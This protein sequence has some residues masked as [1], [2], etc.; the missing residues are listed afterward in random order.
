MRYKIIIYLLLSVVALTGCATFKGGKGYSYK[1]RKK[2]LKEHEIN[3]LPEYDIPVV[4]NDDVIAW[5]EYFQKK[6]RSSFARYL[7]R[8]GR[9][10][11]M[12]REIL[13]QYGV[14]GDMIYSALIESGF[15][16]HAYSR[17]HAVGPWQ[18]IKST[19][20]IYK[21]K[22]DDSVDERRDPVLSTHAAAQFLRDLYKDYGDWYL[23]LA[24]Y[25]AGPGKVNKA[26]KK[27]GSRDFWEICSH[28]RLFREET[29]NHIP[30]I[31]AAAIIAKQPQ[32][33]G[34]AGIE[35]DSPDEYDVVTVESQTDLE[36]V[37]KCA[38]VG[39]DDVFDL[40]PALFRGV[41]PSGEKN[42]Q[43]KVPKGKAKAFALAYAKLPKEDRI[44]YAYHRVKKGDTLSRIARKYGVSVSELKNWNGISNNRHLRISSVLKIY[45]GGSGPK[46]S[47]IKVAGVSK[48]RSNSQQGK[49]YHT[50]KSGETLSHVADRYVVKIKDV[51]RWNGI[52]NPKKVRAGKKLVIYGASGGTSEDG[53][54]VERKAVA[55]STSGNHNVKAG[56]SL[57]SIATAYGMSVDDLK[58]ANG[59]KKNRINPGMKLKV[60]ASAAAPTPKTVTTG[61]V[62]KSSS[63]QDVAVQAP[64][65]VTPQSVAQSSSPSNAGNSFHTVIE[66]ESLWRIANKYGLSIDEVKR[67]NGLKSNQIKPGM[68]LK[69]NKTTLES[70]RRSEHSSKSVM[71]DV[72]KTNTNVKNDNLYRVKNGDSLW[73][74]AKAH[75]VTIA[76]LME[77]NSDLKNSK[78][79]KPGDKLK[80]RV[81]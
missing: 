22:V 60:A 23:V 24:A 14:P 53:K 55:I 47:R 57:W 80:I 16:I 69:V 81:D 71:A 10:E 64:K 66:G 6:G 36:V 18:F 61:S 39:F 75:N 44:R 46:S 31:I 68:K 40:N 26:L 34:F 43:V 50:L 62:D 1:D 30:K 49:F 78:N 27:S 17:A 51:M 2:Y 20:K 37:A 65:S 77:W 12:M 59:L 58:S 13:A 52:S 32:K 76:K 70:T 42:Y 11:K 29:K 54:K 45:R 73:N 21:L 38:G 67:L 72:S 28:R 19:A 7:K 35:Y 74:I 48:K 3:K 25:N 9:Y 56:E 5:L 4:L 41:T 63:S 33:F 8:S 15:N 79:I